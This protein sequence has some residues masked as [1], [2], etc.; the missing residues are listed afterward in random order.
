MLAV[1]HELKRL[2]P[3]VRVVF[4]G[5]RGDNLGDIAANHEDI[6]EAYTVWAGKFRRYHGA[7][8]K[9]VFYLATMVKNARDF[10]RMLIGFMQS[11]RLLKGLK[12]DVMFV[13][14]GMLG[15]PVGLAAASL[16]IP[17]ITHD[18]DALPG[19]GHRI[20]AR[21]A[22]AHAVALPEEV[23]AKYYPRVRT[24]TVGVPVSG[25]FR[26]VDEK[27]QAEYKKQLKIDANDQLL[28]VTGGGNGARLLNEGVVKVSPI[29]LEKFS[30]LRIV[31][32]AGR[33]HAANVERA[34]DE[35][36]G[37]PALRKKVT[38]KGFIEDLYVYSGAA[39]VVVTR[40]GATNI[41]EFAI[42]GKACIIAPN[43]LLTGGHQLKN[44]LLLVENKAALVI[45][46]E[47]LLKPDILAVPII[48][49]LSSEDRRRALGRNL[50]GFAKPGAASELAELILS[51]ANQ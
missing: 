22:K 50:H 9:Q 1:A 11:R 45:D 17:F 15:V 21:W 25:K 48:E 5:Q 44:A 20:I 36:L 26:A 38:V 14:G 33:K 39:D 34:Y 47:N 49:L 23:Y 12:C 37:N 28:F 16:H 29:I 2:K 43:P 51:K 10:F 18:S 31:H 13:K 42:Q 30:G 40:A 4:I 35:L 6:D 7:G 8:V 3:D 46:E 32:V 24:V 41:A 19:L 27:L